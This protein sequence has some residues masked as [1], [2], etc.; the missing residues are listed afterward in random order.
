MPLNHYEFET[1]TLS[2]HH[3]PLSKVATWNDE[4][5]LGVL[6]RKGVH[7]IGLPWSDE[8]DENAMFDS[9]ANGTYDALVLE[10]YILEYGSNTRCD[11]MVVGKTFHEVG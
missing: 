11:V 8:D 10:D 3:N 4:E 5:Y 1:H 7:A 6:K 2:L 9:V